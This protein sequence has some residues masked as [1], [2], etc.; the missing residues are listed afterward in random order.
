[1]WVFESGKSLLP[2]SGRHLSLREML[3]TVAISIVLALLSWYAGQAARSYLNKPADNRTV[4]KIRGKVVKQ[5]APG[6]DNGG[7]ER[8]RDR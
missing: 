3:F 7:S 4:T 5:P 1:M 2:I 6:C 8:R